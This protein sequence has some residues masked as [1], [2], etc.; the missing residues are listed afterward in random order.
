MVIIKSC[1]NELPP[2]QEL[3]HFPL[4]IIIIIIIIPSASWVLLH[5]INYLSSQK[6][7]QLP[8]PYH[9]HHI[10]KTGQI[11]KEV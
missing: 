10:L 6:D 7:C 5:V 4:I 9:L 11:S 3:R 8:F 2:R 1:G